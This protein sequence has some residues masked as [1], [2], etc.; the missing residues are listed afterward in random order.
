MTAL[1][2]AAQLVT[3]TPGVDCSLLTP[4][5]ARG[6]PCAAPV[7][8]APP[9]TAPVCDPRPNPYT[10]PVRAAACTAWE[11]DHTPRPALPTFEVGR[12]YRDGYDTRRMVVLAV[13][14]SLEGVPVV[15]GQYVQPVEWLGL[16]FSFRV[17]Q[18]A[19]WERID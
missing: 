1:F 18:G 3:A 13:S 6:L 10:E 11:R 2:L 16:V 4:L 14:L 8:A 15:T 5:Q 9:V 17:D 7:P 19:P 12:T